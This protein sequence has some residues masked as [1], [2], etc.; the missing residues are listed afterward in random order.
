ML[1]LSAVMLG[2][3][4]IPKHATWKNATGSEQYERL[5]W[6][7]MHKGNWAEA[8]SHLAP[9]FVGVGPAGQLLDRQTWIDYWKQN[10]PPEYAIGE[11]S[12]QPAGGDMVV[13]YVMNLASGPSGHA[14]NTLRVI[15]VWQQ[16][17][18]GW[19]LLGT[20]CTPVATS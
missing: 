9:G 7:T 2:C 11:L 3:A 8:Q 4:G 13:T 14:A 16:V 20:S 12:V 19:I 18:G 10:L 5:M 6:E 1:A 17:K 15:S